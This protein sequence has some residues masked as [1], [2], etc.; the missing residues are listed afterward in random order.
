MPNVM[1]II[2]K[3]PAELIIFV[4]RIAKSYYARRLKGY[5]KITIPHPSAMLKHG[6]RADHAYFDAVLA[7]KNQLKAISNGCIGAQ[8]E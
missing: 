4:G 3:V 1:Q 8:K 5:E 7:L 6:G 2:K